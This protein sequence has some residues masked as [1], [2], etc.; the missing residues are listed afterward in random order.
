MQ[1]GK[2]YL[3]DLSMWFFIIGAIIIV[4]GFIGAVVYFYFFAFVRLKKTDSEALD[5]ASERILAPYRDVVD[6]GFE[7]IDNSPHEWVSITSFDGLRLAARYYP[8]DNSKRTMILFHGYRSLARRDFSC[9]V[10]MYNGMGLN[11][12]LCDQRSHG[13]SEG[14]LITFGIKE[15]R[16]VLSWTRFVLHEYG[17]DTEIFLGGMSMGATTVLLASELG[18]PENVKGIVADCGFTSPRAIIDKVARQSF[19]ISAGVFYW[20]FDLISR[21]VGGFSLYGV[22]TVDAMRKNRIPVLFIHGEDDGFVPCC[23]SRE[24][25]EAATSE[26]RL[27]TVKNADHGFSYLVDT[28]GVTSALWEFISSH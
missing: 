21:A 2:I 8:C 17:E 15:R 12:L 26:K 24:A 6:E 19:H 25:Y 13:R 20:A 22:S 16:D 9:A 5:A 4:L 11:V 28:Y 18:L 14:K 3:G 7:Y 27:V 1:N 10:K 23:M